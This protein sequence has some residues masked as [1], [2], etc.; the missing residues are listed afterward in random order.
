MEQRI[1]LDNAATSPMHPEVIDVMVKSMQDIYGNPSSAH[2]HGRKA[3]NLLEEARGSMAKLLNCQPGEIIFTSGGTEADNTILRGSV[4]NLGVKNIIT[5]PIEHHAVLHTAEVLDQE[6]LAKMHL[7]EIDEAGHINLQ[8]LEKL[9]AENPNSLVSL[10]HGNNEIGNLLSLK[11]VGE[12]AHQYGALFHS[13]TVQTMGQFAMDLSQGYVDFAV[14]A[15]HKFN[16]P[17]GIGFMY[18][19]KKNRPAPLITGGAQERELRSGT[20]N[21]H[22]AVGMAK[23]LEISFRDMEAKREHVLVLKNHMISLLKEEIPGVE[24][25]GDVNGHSLP[26]VLS[27]SFPASETGE[28]LLFNLD[29]SGISA[30][31]GS[32]CSAGANVGSHVIHALHPG[33]DRTTVRFS[34]GKQNTME[35][36]DKTVSLLKTWYP[37]PASV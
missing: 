27:V 11:K 22:A 26:N 2:A 20:E 4:K 6:G 18:C 21:V 34:F 10:M 28:M 19:S 29:I 33:S 35:E 16:G 9:L 37:V 30:S 7:V 13:D 24:F 23:A 12:L 17:K 5:S 8:H 31:G 3:K 15:A 14:G 32:A 25:N 36:I 1:Y